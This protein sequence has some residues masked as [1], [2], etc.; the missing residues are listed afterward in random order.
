MR[1]FQTGDGR[2][3]IKPI[4]SR[5]SDDANISTYYARIAGANRSDTGMPTTA[6]L[7]PRAVADDAMPAFKNFGDFESTGSLGSAFR[8]SHPAAAANF[9]RT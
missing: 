9:G 6:A 4:V 5:F 3:D 1:S 8:R 7:Y 2:H